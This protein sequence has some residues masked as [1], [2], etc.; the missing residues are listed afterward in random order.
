MRPSPRPS[1]AEPAKQTI[2]RIRG[3]VY[4]VE[5]SGGNAIVYATPEGVVL[6]DD[7]NNGDAIVQELLALIRTVTD[8]PVRYV[9][10]TH[11]HQDHIGN[12]GYFQKLGVPVISHVNT[13]RNFSGPV[14]ETTRIVDLDGKFV[15]RRAYGRA[16]AEGAGSRWRR[17]RPSPTSSR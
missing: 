10:N 13:Q 6:V 16:T 2:R 3:D 4:V 12:N 17:R 11:Y 5:G 8:Q 7:K 14:W 9:I 15:A 1:A